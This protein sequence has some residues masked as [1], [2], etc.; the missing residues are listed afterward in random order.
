MKQEIDRYRRLLQEWGGDTQ[1]GIQENSKPP[2]NPQPRTAGMNTPPPASASLGGRAKLGK[3]Q[4]TPPPESDRFASGTILVLNDEELVVYRRG[5]AGQPV[6]M[7]YSLLSD[8][9]AK[10]EALNLAEYQ[11]SELGCLSSDALKTLQANMTWNRALVAPHCAD[12]ADADRIPEPAVPAP[13]TRIPQMRNTPPPASTPPPRDSRPPH[14]SNGTSGNHS[15]EGQLTRNEGASSVPRSALDAE[16]KIRIRRGQRIVLKFGNKA[17]EA[18]YWGRDQTGP[19]VAHS[20]H[21]HWQLMHLDLNRFRDCVVPDEEPDQDLVDEI[22]RELS[23]KV[24]H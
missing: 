7:V 15:P 23:T 4:A 21:K 9:N 2:V 10:I 13:S 1:G 5:V 22:M 14:R 11:V 12:P 3:P 20:T 18:V 8:G 16:G 24:S 6:D 19:V 17:W